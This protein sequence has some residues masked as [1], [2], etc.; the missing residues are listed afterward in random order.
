MSFPGDLLIFY[1]EKSL[2]LSDN[3]LRHTSST[4]MIWSDFWVQ[5]T[6]FDVNILYSSLRLKQLYIMFTEYCE[7]IRNVLP[8]YFSST[9]SFRTWPSK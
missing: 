4:C 2:R 5:A 6:A 1:F 3:L 8:D 7:V 9:C